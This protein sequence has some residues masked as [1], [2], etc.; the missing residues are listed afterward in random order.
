VVAWWGCFCPRRRGGWGVFLYVSFSSGF[1]VFVP[2]SRAGWDEVVGVRPQAQGLFFFLV[3]GVA[4]RLP[5][6]PCLP[7]EAWR[8]VGFVFCPPPLAM[9]GWESPRGFDQGR[10]SPPR[11]S[12]PPELSVRLFVGRRRW[13]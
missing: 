2:R 4:V 13:V 11:P 12:V 8:G 7:Y 6:P 3:G 10:C 5:P 9:A 1:D